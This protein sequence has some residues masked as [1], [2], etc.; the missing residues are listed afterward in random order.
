MTAQPA[1]NAAS[2][3]PASLPYPQPPI[4]ML[5][6]GHLFGK[7]FL[8]CRTEPAA[9]RFAR[10]SGANRYAIMRGMLEK[11]ANP[12]LGDGGD[13][14]ARE[15]LAKAMER[16][17]ALSTR[18]LATLLRMPDPKPLFEAAR[19]LRRSVVGGGVALRGLV[20]ISN[21]CEK[22]CYYCG[23][24]RDNRN[25][26]RYSM[27]AGEILAAAGWAHEAGYGSIVIQGGERR[28]E[29]WTG[30]IEGILREIHTAFGDKLGVTIS[31]GEQTEE[32]YARWLEAGAHRYLL[33]IET[34]NQSL[35]A[36]LHPGDHSWE[37]RLNCLRTLKRLGY[38]TGSGVMCALPG[39]TIED[40]AEDIAFFAA[41]DLDMIG[42]GPYIPHAETPMAGWSGAGELGA[43]RRLD[44]G[45]RMI[46]ATRLHLHDV[47]IAAATALQALAPDGRERGVLAGANVIM[48][49]VT[50]RRYRAEYDLYEGKP[51]LG[52][53]AAQ[54]RGCLER[55][56]AGIGEKILWNRR[57]DPLHARCSR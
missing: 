14:T 38:Q 32:T 30:F 44:L 28:G 51:C 45:L 7:Y 18:E 34:S 10:A 3:H 41:E 9:H 25:P 4:P 29:A 16:P 22:N 6:N 54:C 50:P 42:M 19:S 2:P 11:D 21:I 46:A 13:A 20:E 15:L 56:L 35:Y 43:A 40:L 57:N 24:R 1:Q 8:T 48:P 49:N 27:D 36:K 53:E 37:K 55:R 12:P 26:K 17:R 31:L 47:N 5:L 23:I 33:R 52:E 39:Q